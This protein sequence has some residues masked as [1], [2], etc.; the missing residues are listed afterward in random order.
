MR[1]N[2][3]KER[4]QAV[5][6]TELPPNALRDAIKAHNFFRGKWR[7]AILIEFISVCK[8]LL[9]FALFHFISEFQFT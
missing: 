3:K 6:C 5:G 7:S 9:H 8:I 4:V 1:V 2:E